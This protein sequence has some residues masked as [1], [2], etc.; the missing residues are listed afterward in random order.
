MKIN[1]NCVEMKRQGAKKV[2]RKTAHMSRSEELA[3]WKDRTSKLAGLKNLFNKKR[4][5]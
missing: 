4:T 2:L 5:K 3:F 1:L